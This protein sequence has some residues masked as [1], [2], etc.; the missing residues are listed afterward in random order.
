MKPGAG[1]Y[2]RP[3]VFLLFIGFLN[4]IDHGLTRFNFNPP[5]QTTRPALLNR[6]MFNRKTIRMHIQVYFR[7]TTA[8]RAFHRTTSRFDSVREK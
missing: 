8:I 6:R 5:Y 1:Y 4:Y 2:A 7:P 3:I